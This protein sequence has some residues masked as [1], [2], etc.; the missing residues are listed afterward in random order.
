MGND[1]ERVYG[2]RPSAARGPFDSGG[3][4]AVSATAVME[5]SLPTPSGDLDGMPE[6]HLAIRIAANKRLSKSDLLP[7]FLLFICERA[8]TGNSYEIT[9]QRIG[10]QIFNRP[11]D[12]SP[13]EDNIVR[14][15]ARL[16]RK[17][18]DE[19]FEEEGCSELLRIDIPRGGYVPVFTRTNAVPA[20]SPVL[21]EEFLTEEVELSHLSQRDDSDPELPVKSVDALSRS[22]PWRSLVLGMLMGALLVSALWAGIKAIED[23]AAQS[24]S[25]A[26][27]A[28]IFERNRNTFIVP[29]DSGLGILQNLTGHLVS[30][31]EYA[32]GSYLEDMGP[33]PAVGIANVNDLRRQR[34]TGLA[35]LKITIMLAR[36]PE[37]TGEQSQIRYARSFTTEDLK[38]ANVILLGSSH[39]NPW[40]TLFDKEL[41]FKLKYTPEVNRSFVLNENPTGT[42]QKEYFNGVDNTANRTYGAI[43]YLP[44]L[45][46]TGH[47]LI[48]QGLNMAAT[49]ASA[50]ILFKG[51]IMKP[52]LEQAALPNGSL[53]SFELLVETSSIGATDPGAKVIAT[54]FH[55]Q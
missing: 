49:Q 2:T 53:R 10:T 41:N 32:N 46:G 44:N 3:G 52:I 43:D 33:L 37:Y 1:L 22:I 40:V 31:E 36:L 55:P 20:T 6:W 15:Y 45:D 12:Y 4:S 14:S 51:N 39:S 9:E 17:R 47:V 11:A 24:P 27:W 16:L 29:A 48:I 25:H 5:E 54:R 7:R 30:L 18:L 42:E 35:E 26:L 23:R 28:Q 38:G 8:L 13:G 21:P 34:Y 50:E 19:Y